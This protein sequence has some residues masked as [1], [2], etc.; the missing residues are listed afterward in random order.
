MVGVL[1]G[2]QSLGL[3]VV[4]LGLGLSEAAKSAGLLLAAAGFVGKLVAGKRPHLPNAR[5]LWALAAYVAAGALS[6]ALA[7]P[8]LAGPHELGTLILT[9]AAFPLVVDACARRSR[10]VLL[11]GALI[12]G[13]SAAALAGYAEH[14][15]GFYERLSLPSIENAIPAGEYLAAALVFALAFLFAEWRATVVGPLIC[16]AV[17]SIAIALL[18]TISRGPIAAAAVGVALVVAAGVGKR[19][20]AIAVV[21]AAAAL[22]VLFAAQHPTARLVE[23]G[24]VGTRAAASREYTWRTTARL[25]AERPILGHGLGS[26]A[27]LGVVYED[28]IGTIHQLN[29]HNLYLHVACETGLAGCGTLIVFLVLGLRAALRG[30]HRATWPVE[31]AAAIGGLLGVATLLIAGVFSVS[32]DAEPGILLFT[33]MG[34]AGVPAGRVGD[35]GQEIRGVRGS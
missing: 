35:G 6:I 5:S 27:R 30:Y 28:G 31:R 2:V 20:A 33:L 17:G 10:I 32:S 4:L 23:H 22:A 3:V 29:A 19:W 8:R 25:I 9:V 18:L 13:A 7:K 16:F 11:A 34:L 12:V 15:A 1:D 26:Y 21:V 14:M 24:V